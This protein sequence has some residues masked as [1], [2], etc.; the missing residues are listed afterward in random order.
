MWSNMWCAL[1]FLDSQWY[2][3]SFLKPSNFTR[4]CHFNV[5]NSGLIFAVHGGL[6]QYVPFFCFVLNIRKVSWIKIFDSSSVLSPCFGCFL[7]EL[8]LLL[9]WTFF[10]HLQQLSR[11]L[12]FFFTS[13]CIFDFQ[14]FPSLHRVF[15]MAL[16][17]LFI[18]FY[19][20]SGI[21]LISKTIVFIFNEDI[22]S[23][24]VS[25]IR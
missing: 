15:F 25:S 18:C 13:L 16:S 6:S 3:F 11:S 7:H 21:V 14:H 17:V 5:G 9:F 8:W 1:L 10:T 12:E 23:S 22:S 2:F 19:V 20:P 4:V 24:F